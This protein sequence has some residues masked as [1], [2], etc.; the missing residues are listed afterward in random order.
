M[1]TKTLFASSIIL[2][3]AL[4]TPVQATQLAK[5]ATVPGI[6]ALTG[7]GAQAVQAPVQL[8]AR[9]INRRHSRRH[10]GSSGRRHVRGFIRFH[11]RHFRGFRNRT[12]GRR[13]AS[14]HRRMMRARARAAIRAAHR[15]NRGRF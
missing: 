13:Y 8:A 6:A 3:V 2:G 11:R 4:A 12:S 10:L 1:K 7:N 9:T 14:A 15:R 5:P